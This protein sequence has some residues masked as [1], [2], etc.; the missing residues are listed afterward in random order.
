LNGSD[1]GVA[2]NGKADVLKALGWLPEALEAYEATIRDFPQD[3]VARN[4]KAEVLKELGRLPEALEAYEATTREFAQDVVARNGKAE[5]LKELGRLTEALE[6]YEATIRD[7]AT[8]GTDSSNLRPQ[9]D[10]HPHQVLPIGSPYKGPSQR[11]TPVKD[12]KPGAATP[13]EL[14]LAA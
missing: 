14:P 4:G 12:R 2:R 3:A 8:S 11:E 13:Q 6:A 1:V 9:S 5:V 7:I 10:L